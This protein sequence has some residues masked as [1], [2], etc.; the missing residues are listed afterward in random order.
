[1]LQL[2]ACLISLMLTVLA[3]T[4]LKASAGDTVVV[5]GFDHFLHQ[6]CNSGTQRFLFPS[7]TAR[8]YKVMLHYQLDCPSFGCDIYDRIAT[9]K[10]LRP[11]GRFDSTLTLA[12]SFTVNGSTVDTFAC[13]LDTTFSYR[14]DTLSQQ[15][16]SLALPSLTV[17]FY[18]DP[19]QPLTPTDTLTAWPLSYHQYVFDSSGT[20]IDSV[21]LAPDTTFF[22]SYD[23]VWSAPFE[24]REPVE[25]ARAITPFGEA[26]GLWFDVSDYSDLLRDSVTLYTMVCGY[27]N[28]WEVTTDFYFIEGEPFLEPYRLVNLWNGTWQYGNSA[29]P[30]DSHLQPISVPGDTTAG[31]ARIRLITT[32]HGFGGDPNPEV[33]EFYD[34]THHLLV[35]GDSLAQRLWRADCGLNP[36][37]PQGAPGYSSTWYYRRANWCPGSFVTPHDYVVTDQMRSGNPVT[38]DYEMEPYTVTG[39]PP[40]F[41]FPE[42]YIQSQAIYYRV[43]G[44]RNNAALLEIQRPNDAF[45]YNRLNPACADRHPMVRFRNLGADTLRSLEFHYG[46]DGDQSNVFTWTGSLPFLDTLV[47]GLPLLNQP[48]GAHS[49]S[50]VTRNPNGVADEFVADDS[51]HC[52]FSTPALYNTSFVRILVKTDGAPDEISTS[53]TDGS[54]NVLFSRSNYPAAGSLYI[55]TVFLSNGC[56]SFNVFDSFGDGLCCFGGSGYFRVLKGG[57]ATIICNA[58]DFGENFTRQAVIDFNVGI[59]DDPVGARAF[60]W[61]NPASE[62]L[63]INLSV[64]SDWLKARIFDLSGRTLLEVPRL[65]VNRH[66]AEVDVSG[67]PGGLYFIE[68][69]GSGWQQ[70]LRWV[71]Q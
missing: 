47:I 52:T 58:N 48:D 18:N 13:A 39:G 60:L 32:G 59:D 21:L 24:I 38:V 45:E 53:V 29:N 31:F 65:I 27:S 37:Y 7:D 3:G 63:G 11:T 66:E 6:N 35:N 69:T 36:L 26:V 51:L 33:A 40:G 34:V 64:E 14:F 22:L 19:L 12:P 44:Y 62:R 43:P 68:L 42:Y 23:S 67:L 2:R 70:V 46:L 55:D 61:P 5:R 8:F 28:G 20:A 30:I 25:I 15:I 71:R 54:G 49:F 50:V 41:Y 17:L 9:L 10:L 57:T 4:S 16:D 1:M 56:Y